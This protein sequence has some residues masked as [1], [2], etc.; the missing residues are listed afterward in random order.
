MRSGPFVLCMVAVAGAAAGAALVMEA[1]RAAAAE[2]VTAAS[3]TVIN[4][5]ATEDV[6]T[7]VR[8]ASEMTTRGDFAQAA[9]TLS[10]AL[11]VGPETL[12]LHVQRGLL[13]LRLEDVDGAREDF[14][15]A[16]ALEDHAAAP[17]AVEQRVK[18]RRAAV[19]AK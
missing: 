19:L 13:R 11:K 5:V 14:N 7:L 4:P 12:Q 15:R 3:L 6:A 17:V 10:R 9:D 18:F 2:P 16:L 1:P 8:L